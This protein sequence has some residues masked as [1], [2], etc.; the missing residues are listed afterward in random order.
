MNVKHKLNSNPD[1]FMA[2]GTAPPC[3]DIKQA[4]AEA[5]LDKLQDTIKDF[6]LPENEKHKKKLGS[7]Y[8]KAKGVAKDL[9]RQRR[10]KELPF[11][12]DVMRT[13]RQY[14]TPPAQTHDV[15]CGFFL[16]LGE[17]EEYTR[18]FIISLILRKIHNVSTS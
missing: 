7:D 4:P 16:L 17:S 3:S 2:M 9:D 12:A 18:V 1:L 14:N 5:N 6:E 15:V 11:G 10:I 8:D 13:L